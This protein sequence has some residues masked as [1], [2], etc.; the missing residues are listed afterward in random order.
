MTNP[1]VR[2]KILKAFLHE[3]EDLILELGDKIG[4]NRSTPNRDEY[5][6]LELAGFVEI[7]NSDKAHGWYDVEL[8]TIGLVTYK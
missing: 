4:S 8:S 5:M 1:Y 3:Q 2:D 6:L 7:K